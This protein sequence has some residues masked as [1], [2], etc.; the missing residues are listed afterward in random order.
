M[1]MTSPGV[2]FQ[3]DSFGATET[4]CVAQKTT[5]KGG[6]AMVEGGLGY[7]FPVH[8]QAIARRAS[9]GEEAAPTAASGNQGA[10]RGP[11]APAQETS[12]AGGR[13]K[14]PL[15]LDRAEIPLCPHSSS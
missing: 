5:L 12:E 4:T 11:C 10:G 2:A 15:K 8:H 3:R 9:G 1:Q 13:A 7:D 6:M 14:A